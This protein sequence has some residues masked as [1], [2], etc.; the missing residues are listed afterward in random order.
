MRFN[1]K[2]NDQPLT[3]AM[4]QAGRPANDRRNMEVASA[5]SMFARC[6]E[7]SGRLLINKYSQLPL[8]ENIRVHA[9]SRSELFEQINFE[10]PAFKN[11]MTHFIFH[12]RPVYLER[13]IKEP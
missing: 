11:R 8:V 10:I 2:T 3:R 12:L 13:T 7:Y 5:P 6:K 9:D 4:H 1:M